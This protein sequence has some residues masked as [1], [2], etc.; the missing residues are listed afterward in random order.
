MNEKLNFIKQL[1]F[2]SSLNS[3]KLDI[4]NSISKI[5]TYPK[6]SILYYEN[7]SSNKIFFLVSGLLKVYKIDKFEN[8]IFLYHIHKNSLISELTTLNDDLIYCFSN[9][10][11]MEESIVLEVS[12]QELKTEFLS[13]NIL[14]NEFINEILLKTQQLHCVVNRE[15]VFD[16]TAKVAFT[17]YNDLEMFNSLKRH[18]V[19]F[20]LHIQPETLSRVL[21][22]LK[23]S[24]I[25]DIE[26]SDI[27]V[28]N[29]EMLKS[30]YRGE[31]P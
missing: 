19:S 3:E 29:K 26:N 23:R 24:S 12:F 2:F 13:K 28:L 17:L 10:E 18:E 11:F 31:L 8:E 5:T 7:D 27:I 1:S 4:V 15:L 6:N 25:I 14:N 9:A 30:T 16:A 22:K 21:K 20:M